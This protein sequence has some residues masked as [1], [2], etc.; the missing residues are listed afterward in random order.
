MS[1]EE[2]N[3][4]DIKNHICILEAVLFAAGYPLQFDKLAT[5]LELSVDE[6]KSLALELQAKYKKM[7]SGIQLITYKTSCQLSTKEEYIDYVRQAL[8]I[9]RGGN[10]S[11]ASL[12][13]LA[14]IAY[15]QPVTR[16]YIDSVRGVD[17]TY[18]VSSLVEK[19]LIE[20][21]GQLDVP[22]RP[23]LYGTSDSFL[24]CFGLSDVSE[25]PSFEKF[26][27]EG[28]ELENGDEGVVIDI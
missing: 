18:T 3:K 15:N 25:L 28:E 17:S 26:S 8:D 24:R 19:N 12:E 10:L 5:V 20:I 7:N 11:R 6:V 21:K 13:T 22:G 2:K 4:E 16:S 14:V 1:G 27:K 9:K 23:N